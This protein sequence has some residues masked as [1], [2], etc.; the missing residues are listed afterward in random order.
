I[1]PHANPIDPLIAELHAADG[2]DRVALR[3]GSRLVARLV[4]AVPMTD[5]GADVPQVNTPP[6]EAPT[7]RLE[8]ATRGTFDGLA[9]K[10]AS[11]RPPAPG[12]VEIRVYAS[13]LNFRDVMNV[14]AMR[15]DPEPLGSECSGRV[16]RVGT[17][18]QGVKAGDDVIAIAAGS[19]GSYVTTRVELVVPKPDTLS[20]AEAAAL[21]LAFL[22][23]YYA[24]HHVARITAH[25][26]VLIHAAAGGVGLAAV[27]LAQRAGAEIYATAGSPAKRE[28][29]AALGVRH[30]MSSRTL[31][32]CDVLRRSQP[33]GVSVV[34][35]SLA[36]EFIS[37]SLDA[38]CEDGRFLEIGKREI[39]SA[40]QVAAVKPHATY[41]A[42]DLAAI[43]ANDPALTRQMLLEVLDTL[44]AGVLKPLPVQ[45]FALDEAADAFRYMAQAK[46]IGKIV[47]TQPDGNAAQDT[48]RIRPAATYLITGGLGGLGLRTARWLVDKG[49]R[50]VVLGGRSGA[51]DEAR[52]E[53]HDLE[54]GGAQ[55]VVLQ[56][57]IAQM[58]Q[59]SQVLARIDQ[60]M[61][62]LRGVIHAAGVLDDGALLQQTW[63]RFRTVMAAKV[64]GAWNLHVLTRALPLDFF[65][66]FSSAAALFGSRGQANHAAANAFMD[67]L[68]HYRR[69]CALSALSIN[70]GAWAQIG[71]AVKHHV[72]ERA[73]TQGV[74][75][76]EPE[77][78]IKILDQMLG[79]S[80]TLAFTQVGVVP[81]EWPEYARR[82]AAGAVPA[83][84]VDLI[85]NVQPVQAGDQRQQAVVA[86]DE[87]GKTPP[88]DWADRLAEAPLNRRRVLLITYV[89]EQ[90]GRVLGINQNK[91]RERVA[92]N[93]V[94]LDSLMAV[95]LRNLLG[96]GLGLK[97][98]L[99]ATLVFDYPSIEALAGYLEDEAL[100]SLLVDRGAPLQEG[101]LSDISV[102]AS[103][104]A[105][106]GVLETLE[107]MSDEEVDRLFA[108][109]MKNGPA[110]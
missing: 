60:D 72:T 42:I 39:Y 48:A 52:A 88:A 47:I 103:R 108:E 92:L 6:G 19:F 78:G 55:I 109:K 8:L 59:V 54:R 21:P 61:P 22:T 82:F 106:T 66:L 46:H 38:L 45:T 41:T 14:L 30:A 10:E 65:V 9:L 98:A 97:H 5:A 86:R 4:H 104:P 96:S 32:F 15:D 28:C 3:N 33:E 23:A 11:R 69:A 20:Y 71:A 102:V 83:L 36:G 107:E 70:W 87:T 13:G 77:Q 7:Q 49:A 91:L 18:V 101:D 75:V 2:E 51:S 110:P 24:L 31:D 99:P 35:N 1:D 64:A 43:I 100:P 37:K 63:A 73:V 84:L 34:L 44:R 58:D 67:A 25:D 85:S 53:L 50:H 26:K 89:Q 62:P 16:V 94:G 17:G 74:G 81:F 90:A 12:E 57:D 68:A 27:Q 93:E 29:L 80:G 105:V 56:A 95:E 76:I 79:P 40:Q